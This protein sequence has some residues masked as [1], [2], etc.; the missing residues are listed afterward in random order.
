MYQKEYAIDSL[1]FYN[2]S[3]RKV[4]NQGSFEHDVK[5]DNI[6]TSKSVSKKKSPHLQGL[7]V[8]SI[9]I[10]LPGLIRIYLL[11][12]CLPHSELFYAAARF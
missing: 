12:S 10:K 9:K 2:V 7:V 1:I 6:I 8:L 3:V 4:F 11:F 5:G